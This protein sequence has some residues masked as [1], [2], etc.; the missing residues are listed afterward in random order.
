MAKY[1]GRPRRDNIVEPFAGSAGYSVYWNCRNVKLYDIDHDVVEMWDYLIYCSERDIER[2]PDWIDNVEQVLKLELQAEVNLITR[3]LSFGKRSPLTA[4]SSLST[5]DEFRDHF[6]DGKPFNKKMPTEGASWSPTV[7]R[8]IIKQKP[9]IAN[10][11]ADLLDYKDVP[12]EE[13]HWFIDPPYQSQMKVY[14]K[15]H[16]IDFAHLGEWSKS[17]QGSVDVCEQ[18][19]AD[20]LDFKPIKR[21]VNLKR[22]KYTEV[23]WRNERTE[24]F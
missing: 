5:Y 24:L 19:G 18:S 3:W 8:R 22:S 9:L 16:V 1:Y 17:R 12:N 23:I 7:K 2:L 20:W 13:A 15:E 6:R 21:N 14:D 10:W 4:S 11:K